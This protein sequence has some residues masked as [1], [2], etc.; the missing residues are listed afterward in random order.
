[1][2]LR[3]SPVSSMTAGN[4]RILDTIPASSQA[5]W[6]RAVGVQSSSELPRI[7]ILLRSGS[8]GSCLGI[9]SIGEGTKWAQKGHKTRALRGFAGSY[10][11]AKSLY[12]FVTTGLTR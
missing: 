1:M 11:A 12:C 4:R 8:W 2:E 3:E 6:F 5:S 9:V 7:L 10:I